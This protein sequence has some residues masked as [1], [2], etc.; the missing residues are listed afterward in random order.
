[1][2]KRHPALYYIRY[3]LLSENAEPSSELECFGDVN[4]KKDIRPLF[5]EVNT[6]FNLNPEWTARQKARHMGEFLRSRTK[7]GPALSLSSEETLRGMLFGS[8]GVCG[9]FSLVFNVFCLLN[10]IPS[11]EYNVVDQ[12]YNPRY[13]HTFNEIYDRD[14][15]K[16]IAIDVHKG[17]W[18]S[19][20]RGRLLSV[21]ELFSRLKKAEPVGLDYYSDYRPPKPER[22]PLVYSQDAVAYLVARYRLSK[23]DPF[24]DRAKGVPMAVSTMLMVITG[25]SYR[26][27]FITHDYRS[28]LF[29]LFY[30][31]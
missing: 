17:I 9:D 15:G 1:M 20:T 2:I 28:K 31:G 19:D 11:R 6:Q 16:W 5:F 23:I 21:K 14:L 18:F 22:L 24:L 10:D 8:G 25:K 4:A 26:F 30:S 7:A 13:G 3:L 27:Q 29:P 12:M